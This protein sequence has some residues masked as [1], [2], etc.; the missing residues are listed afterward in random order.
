MLMDYIEEQIQGS[1][2]RID[3]NYWIKCSLVI[4]I[5]N[6]KRKKS[7]KIYVCL[8]ECYTTWIVVSLD[9]FS[10]V[11]WSTQEVILSWWLLYNTSRDILYS[12]HFIL[13]STFCTCYLLKLI[14][15]TISIEGKKNE[16]PQNDWV[17]MEPSFSMNTVHTI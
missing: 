5:K 2:T 15:L 11:P 10:H 13:I 16:M 17:P 12:F 8:K 6:V 4:K 14:Y 9:S 7:A 1:F 3:H